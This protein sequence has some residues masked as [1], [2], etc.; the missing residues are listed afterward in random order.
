VKY[1]GAIEKKQKQLLGKKQ[2]SSMVKTT[3]TTVDIYQ[4]NILVAFSS[5]SFKIRRKREK[6]MEKEREER[7][8]KISGKVRKCVLLSG[9]RGRMCPRGRTL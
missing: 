3:F 7:R 8:E 1:L 2:R 5:E 4:V 6:K 9:G